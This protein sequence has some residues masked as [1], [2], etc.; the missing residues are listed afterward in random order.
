[1]SAVRKQRC[2]RASALVE[3]ARA[4]A[5]A[6]GRRLRAESIAVDSPSSLCVAVSSIPVV[7]FVSAC[8]MLLRDL[9]M[10][11]GVDEGGPLEAVDWSAK[12]SG[13]TS[14]AIPTRS[15]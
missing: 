5:P 14:T 4:S 9:R 11:A 2:A 15:Y 7:S 10:C 1:V 3:R 6:G 8:C 13:R 12:A